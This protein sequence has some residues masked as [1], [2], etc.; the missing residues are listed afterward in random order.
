MTSPGSAFHC[1]VKQTLSDACDLA[2]ENHNYGSESGIYHVLDE[3]IA[4]SEIGSG[5]SEETAGV[6]VIF[7]D[8]DP[9]FV[10]PSSPKAFFCSPLQIRRLILCQEELACPCDT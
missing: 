6:E 9:F 7:D 1:G 3:N 4:V 10:L 5:S 8:H 2:K